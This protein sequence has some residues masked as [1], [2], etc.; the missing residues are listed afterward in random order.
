MNHSSVVLS[1]DFFNMLIISRAAQNNMAGR[2]LHMSDI[3]YCSHFKLSA[4]TI[5]LTCQK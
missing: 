1:K 3:E 2:V 5:A 4:E